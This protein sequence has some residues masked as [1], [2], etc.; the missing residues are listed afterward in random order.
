MNDDALFHRQTRLTDSSP[1]PQ[2]DIYRSVPGTAYLAGSGAKGTTC[3]DC[4]Y[5]RGSC[6]EFARMMPG[7]PEIAVPTETPSCKYFVDAPNGK[8]GRTFAL[9][10][11]NAGY[12][13]GITS[14]LLVADLKMLAATGYRAK[15]VLADPPWKFAVR[16][17]RGKHRSPERHYAVMSIEEIAALGPLVRDVTDDHAALFLWVSSPMLFEARAV[18]EAWGFKYKTVAFNWAKITA[19]GKAAIGLGYW[20]RAGS[21]ICLLAIRGRPKRLAQDIPQLLLAGRGAHSEKPI[22]IHHRIEK[23]LGEV[24]RLELFAREAKVGWTAWGTMEGV[25]S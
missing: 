21:E 4:K 22:E 3:G 12:M 14:G 10:E 16:S 7:S 8:T 5:W 9:A 2:N 13:A 1:I 17:E 11:D 25:Q 23:L 15:V 18:I 19:A 20:T 24:P 6:E